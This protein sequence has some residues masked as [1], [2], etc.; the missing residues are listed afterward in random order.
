MQVFPEWKQKHE[1][2]QTGRDGVGNKRG[3]QSGHREL[4][5]KERLRRM[6]GTTGDPQ[7]GK[8]KPTTYVSPL[9]TP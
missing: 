5:D 7:T 4:Q 2:G 9:L 8:Q 1:E 6:P 3:S